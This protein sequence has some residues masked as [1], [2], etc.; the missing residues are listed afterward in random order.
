MS[1]RTHLLQAIHDYLDDSPD[2]FAAIG[3]Q[4]YTGLA[5]RGTLPPYVIVNQISAVPQ[6]TTGN[7]YGEL[8]RLQVD[9]YATSD[10]EALGLG[11]LITETLDYSPLAI[12]SAFVESFQRGGGGSLTVE[13]AS[14]LDGEPLS[15][16]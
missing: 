16:F 6:Y 3:D 2:V 7:A 9:V 10:L 14:D 4:H 13:E 12:N 1:F 8:V 11:D 15:R 5:R